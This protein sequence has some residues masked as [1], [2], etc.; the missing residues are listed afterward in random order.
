MGPQ[1]KFDKKKLEDIMALTHTQEGMLFHYMKDP[2]SLQYFEQL[3]LDLSGDVDLRR[4]ERAWNVVVDTN[5]ML[6]TVFRWKNIEKPMQV[7]L[8]THPLKLRYYDFSNRDNSEKKKAFQEIIK[9][10]ARE[11]FDLSEVPFRIILCKME[12]A[13]YKVVIS[14]HHILY[15]GWSS[16]IILKEFFK[17]YHHLAKGNKITAPPVK[18]KFKE[19]VRW[20]QTRETQQQREFWQEYLKGFDEKIQLSIKRKNR[21]GQKGI[22]HH[23]VRFS[24]GIKQELEYLVK[25][26]NITI[27]ALLYTAWGVLLQKYNNCDDVLFGT[28][29]S[30]RTA[31]IKGIEDMAGLFINTVPLR[32]QNHPHE[33][34]ADLLYRID[35]TLQKRREYEHSSLVDIKEYS[36]MDNREE[37]FDSVVVIENYPLRTRFMPG[38]NQ[39][40]L[41]VDSY[42]MLEQTHYDLT[43]TVSTHHDIE[44]TFKCKRELFDRDSIVRLSDHFRFIAEDIIKTPGKEVSNIELLSGEEKNKILYEFNN[45][46]APYPKDKTLQQLFEEQVERAPD[47]IALVG[48]GTRFIASDSQKNTTHLTYRELNRKSNQLAYLLKEKG[49]RT[50]G[51][52][53]IMVH[54][55]LEMI[56]G[57]LGILKAGGA[58]LPIEP[59][60]PKDRINYMLA[61]SNVRVLL[62][63]PELQ[64][65][66]KAEFKA[67]FI[68]IV[69]ISSLS[70]FSTSACQVSPASLAYVIYTSGSTGKPKG[71]LVEHSS[72]VNLVFS[73][74]R[75]FN[76]TAFD[77]ILQF[78]SICFDAS[79]EQIFIALLSGA[80]LVLID[81]DTLLDSNKFAEF[82]NSRSVTHLHAV[83][84]FLTNMK[85]KNTSHLKRIISGGDV[86]HTVLAKKW[87][88]YCDFYNKYGPTETTVTSI[89]MLVENVDETLSRLPIGKPLHNTIVYLLDG[90][91]NPVPIGVI[92]ELYIG[93]EGVARGYLN[94]VEL[95]AEKF[96]PGFNRSYKS[97]IT[98]L[99]YYKTGDL[100]RWLPD[101]NIEFLGRIDHQVKIRGF[102]I[103][104]GEIEN[105][106]L[107]HENVKEAIVIDRETSQGEKYL[108][109]YLV[110]DGSL[111]T[112]QLR[113]YLL[114]ELPGYMI[115]A[116]FTQIDRIPL[117]SS[118][119]INGRALPIPEIT[120]AQ[121]YAAPRN[122]R[123]E[124]LVN[125]WSDVLDINREQIGIDHHFFEMGGHSLKTV[126]L[127]ARIYKELN[128]ELALP[129]I[130]DILTVR[131]LAQYI[132]KK[133]KTLY[134]AIEPVEKK[135]YY[136]SSPA[137]KRLFALHQKVPHSLAY[138]ITGVMR[139]KGNFRE[140]EFE[141][142]FKKIIARHESLR[143]SFDVIDGEPVQKI[144]HNVEFK[145]EYFDLQVTGA[146][147]R[148]QVKEA[149]FGQ[150]NAFGE[151]EGEPAAALINSFTRPFDLSRVPLMRVGLIKLLHTPT[152]LRGHPSQEGKEDKCLLM[153]DMHHIISD[154][155]SAGIMTKELMAFYQGKG[156]PRLKVQYKDFV[157]WQ[158][159]Q[160]QPGQINPRESYWLKQFQTGD[161]IPILHLPTDYTRPA[162]K[163][164]AG[165]TITFELTKEETG[166]LNHLALKAK[167]TQFIV[168]L[169]AFNV[170]ISKLSGQEDIVIGIPVSGRR[171]SD[172]EVIVGMFVNTLAIRNYPRGRKTFPGFLEE[173]GENF[174]KAMENQ[175]YQ[176]ED[177]VEKIV[178]P[179]DVSRNPLFDVMLVL[180]NIE[181]GTLEIPGLK[182]TPTPYAGEFAKFDMTFIAEEKSNS[183][184]FSVSYS[185]ALFKKETIEG[186]TRCFKKVISVILEAPH[187]TLSGIEILSAEEKWR[188]LH[189][190][191]DT[192]TG[193]PADK[194][195]HRLFEEQSEQTPHHMAL[196]GKDKGWKGRRVEGKRGEAPTTYYD[197]SITY[198]E[199]NK[200]S[201]QLAYLLQAKGVRPDS[202]VG[203]MVERSLEMIIGVL[204]ILK[205]GGAYL[206]LDPEYPE[207]RIRYILADSKVNVLVKNSNI[208]SDLESKQELFVLNFEH[209]DFEFVSNF[210]F[211]ASNLNSSNLAYVIYTSG[212]TGQP[213]GVLVEHRNAVNVV[214]WFGKRYS[215]GPGVHVLQMSDYTFDPSVNQ[216]FGTLHRG[217]LLCL[218]SR[219][220]LTDVELLWQHIK[221]HHIHVLNFVPLVLNELL[222]TGPKLASIRVVLSGGEKL[223]NLVKDAILARG[224]R[225]YNQYGPTE[226]TIDALVEECSTD[227][228]TLGKPI[229]NVRCYIVDKDNNLA[230]IGIP[231]EL[232]VAGAG[233]ARGY[234]NNPV[235]TLE[236]FDQ[237][238]WDYQDKKINQK[239]LRGESRCFTGAVFSKSAPPGR[240][241]QKIYKTGDLARWLPEGNIE[242]LGR[243]DHQV[244]I[245]GFRIE[246]EEIENQLLRLEGI[247]ECV[248]TAR[249]TMEGNHPG[250]EN[251]RYLCAYYVSDSDWDAPRLKE[252]LSHQVPGYMVPLYFVPMEYL[253]LTATGKIDRDALSLLEPGASESRIAPANDT[254]EILTKIWSE[255]LGVIEEE[256]SM[257]G[258]FFELGGHSLKM[259]VIASKVHQELDIK[260]PLQELFA[261][262]TIRELAEYLKENVKEKHVSI[263]SVEKKEYYPTSS[264][265]KRLNIL[266][267]MNLNN[268]QYNMPWV[269]IMEGRLQR[270][271]L[272]EIFRVLIKR[273][274]SLRTSYLVVEEEP[275]QKPHE[276]VDFN[277]E[278]YDLTTDGIEKGK[279]EEKEAGAH[280]S[281]KNRIIH[282]SFIRPF[283]LSQVPLLRV[284]LIKIGTSNHIF[285]IDMHHIA[286]DGFSIDIL[287]KEFIAL[288]ENREP[289]PL[290]IQ[291]KDYSQWRNSPGEKV[292]MD[293]QESYWLQA[294]AGEIPGIN[295]PTDFERPPVQSYEGNILEF[296]LR[297]EPLGQLR[298]IAI[299]KEATLYMTI[300]AVFNIL[301]SRISGQRDII[302][303]VPVAGRQH[304]DLRHTIGMFVNMLVLR[305]HVDEEKTFNE[306]L[307]EVKEKTVKALENQDYLFED[308]VNRLPVKRD[309]SRN[310]L[311]D[312]IYDL[313]KVE[314]GSWKISN[315]KLKPYSFESGVSKFDMGLLGEDLGKRVFFRFEYRTKLFK[316]E[317]IERFIK[318]FNEL[319]H[320]V[321]GN[322]NVTL[323]NIEISH[324]LFDK[325]VDNPQISFG[326]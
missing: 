276:D 207:E 236:K 238:F 185:T 165:G 237:D 249:E 126:R 189:E 219:E 118:G 98:H 139:L 163:N 282:H 201:D 143:T 2:G 49:V 140:D 12:E 262:L 76:M 30:G 105:R 240:R 256:I 218:I 125:I 100:A 312:V 289:P 131:Q 86:C 94:R 197:I 285:M 89:E 280:H 43:L 284:G 317:T 195:L 175:D 159:E 9:R 167:A 306:F 323:N 258:N 117:T 182:L 290:K 296:E 206:P 315:L 297:G 6:R 53:S 263:V 46:G 157:Q 160:S 148:L 174:L 26:S 216:V 269:I 23:S 48:V 166:A 228:V 124:T 41:R 10:D 227:K 301:L 20:L 155:V 202:I 5:E 209:L 133:E 239:F 177:L 274:E 40:S 211:R 288:Y 102:R 112:P 233:V 115:P 244:K 103:E 164:F 203:L 67:R 120:S 310:P 36:G 60:Y 325:R 65:K 199:L 50:D 18:T 152:A 311:F 74:V 313:Q 303:G 275:V 39:L 33:K 171:H 278:Y 137:Q 292:R 200:K 208:I 142:A 29:V 230:P 92:G 21:Q 253:P 107:T 184:H 34:A 7:I 71:V 270:E 250:N 128:I 78:S 224:Y 19:Y 242:F 1:N 55:S 231:G 145:I 61:D 27:A 113:E 205:A 153:V 176:F 121:T 93:G 225:L 305:N 178:A 261:R 129:E 90:Y 59:G 97:Y 147:S 191:N 88:K 188:I 221:K 215:L 15:D 255:V 287:V 42:S 161:E 25:S 302:I 252:Y 170:F 210:E 54:R 295:M 32:I 72:V 319:V 116:Y 279:V 127:I 265:Q 222:S 11:K 149:P 181:A 150:I 70:S 318:Y 212:S 193:Y 95:T 99:S 119:K 298:K 198:S 104:L 259:T 52:I 154:G 156:L 58:Y 324:E 44:V 45:T 73:Q 235:L 47:Y 138:N 57:I 77:R 307:G 81:K 229:S 110:M 80:T 108:C 84:S 38:K 111:K 114:K 24:P 83:P 204:G 136:A 192:E 226:T 217:A 75:F 194:T 267:R 14:S 4:F 35:N 232:H 234:L 56:I 22:F 314:L 3:C 308:L 281:S 8:K 300:M 247:K 180:Q 214:S 87:N 63:T 291:Y 257:D 321:T 264:A 251:H 273:H 62:T 31:K 294:L 179:M 299:Q 134:P 172:L 169:A 248:V 82:I 66:V 168:L 183:L 123:E 245:R 122:K 187:R 271:K 293:S 16:G 190:F 151:E 186:F 243:L 322:P 286:A 309:M 304:V 85:L 68:E 241:R 173:V 283:N 196:V 272:E 69:D 79:G 64:V 268:T 320:A 91:M 37:L 246:L 130:F 220:A 13:K 135:G 51:I 144:H 96:L 277:V 101:G 132:G 106:L 109:S 266:Q 162:D 316:K 28:T 158:L 254:E 260:V 141:E 213:K 146:G 17:A 326:F 223:D